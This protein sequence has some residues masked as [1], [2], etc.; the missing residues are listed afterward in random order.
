MLLINDIFIGA[1]ALF[2]RFNEGQWNVHIKDLNCTG[3]EGTFWDCPHNGFD[4][5]TCNHYDVATV[6]CQCK[7]LFNQFR[8]LSLY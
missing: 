2:N 6:V 7:F 5:N 8:F 3:D 4:N 1:S